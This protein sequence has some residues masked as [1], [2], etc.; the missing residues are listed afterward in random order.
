[1]PPP[2]TPLTITTTSLPKAI[3]G[4]PYNTKLQANGGSPSYTW[5]L[6]LFPG[7]TAASVLPAG[8][9]FASDGTLSGT[10]T[11][12]CYIVW[13]PQFQVQDAAGRT[14]GVGLELDCVAPLTFSSNVL[15]NGNIAVPYSFVPPVQGGLTPYQYSV[16]TGSL[17][18]G[19]T[20]DK[21]QGL[22]GT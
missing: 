2:S 17:P 5:S 1:P 18:P 11:P 16:T 10:A 9:A 7:Q 12:G 19:M 15:P 6:A 3:T 20:I 8:L 14:A 4:A 13:L 22:Q 21:N